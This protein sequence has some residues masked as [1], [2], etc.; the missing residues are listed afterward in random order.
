MTRASVEHQTALLELQRLDTALAR[1]AHQRRTLPVLSALADLEATAADLDARRVGAGIALADA[2]RDLARI[3]E[4]VEKVQNRAARHQAR[5]IA[6]ASA[7]DAQAI[8]TELDLLAART[9]ELEDTQLEQMETV[10]GAQA[11]V[12]RLTA[13]CAESADAIA[14]TAAERDEEFARL[15]TERNRL[16][17]EREALAAG[18]PP[19]LVALYDQVRDETG[20]LGAVALHGSRTEGVSI[21]FTVS[22][23]DAIRSASPD[24]VLTSEE[25]GY[26]LVRL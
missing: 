19:D 1:L 17:A 7:K 14:A 24:E 22:E 26:I 9:A 15:D 10:E 18:L 5:L 12:D 4:D 21:D 2:R 25:H 13:R 3:E 8:Q 23:L 20:G 6:G 16:T 11:E